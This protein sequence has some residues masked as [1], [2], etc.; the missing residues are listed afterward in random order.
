MGLNCRVV[1]D[2]FDNVVGVLAPNGKESVL[3]KKALVYLTN[4]ETG[5]TQD[6]MNNALTM[7]GS[8]YTQGFEDFFTDE[9]MYKNYQTDIN[10]EPVLTDVLTYLKSTETH[11]MGIEGKLDFES[12]RNQFPEMNYNALESKLYD[13]FLDED[14]NFVIDENKISN[15]GLYLQEEIDNILQDEKV[16]NSIK[17]NVL[18]INK[19]N[20]KDNSEESF[21][22][23]VVGEKYNSFGKL[24]PYDSNTLM[25]TIL[26]KTTDATDEAEFDALLKEV[27]P[28]SLYESIAG[29]KDMYNSLLELSL[30]LKNVTVKRFENGEMVDVL[31]RD[32]NN[33][34]K[35]TLI[36]ANVSPDTIANL[37]TLVALDLDVILNNFEDFFHLIRS[38]EKDL[39]DSN[40][41]V[42]GLS[43]K[44]LSED[45]EKT[46]AFLRAL[47]KFVNSVNR[48]YVSDN[49]IDAYS[50]IYTDYFEIKGRKQFVNVDAFDHEVVKVENEMTK[51]EA[52]ANGL[53]HVRDNFYIPIVS[54]SYNEILE[55]MMDSYELGEN[56]ME[57]V[58]PNNLASE[59]QFKRY[60][61]NIV[62]AKINDF[63]E[64]V[65]EEDMDAFRSITL[66][67]TLYKIDNVKPKTKFTE[68]DKKGVSDYVKFE[69]FS[70][71]NNII[72]RAKYSGSSM[73]EK[74]F[75]YLEFKQD[76]LRITDNEAVVLARI[77]NVLPDSQVLRE[78]KNYF[79]EATV[80]RT[81]DTNY[82]REFYFTNPNELSF[83][84]KGYTLRNEQ[85]ITPLNLDD[86]IQTKEGVFEK[87]D[88]VNG[89]NVY[90][91]LVQGAEKVALASINKQFEG[92]PKVGDM[93]KLNNTYTEKQGTRIMEEI[94]NCK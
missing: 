33:E 2:N 21:L 80:V 35:E 43:E 52:F 15:S 86:F 47:D 20:F 94:N 68:L 48:G 10:G 22:N 76:E 49:I 84:N 55:S 30:S 28:E 92:F 29:N 61:D 73:Y 11:R 34:L 70:D 83:I 77:E 8:A 4:K 26:G 67:E 75:K 41:D 72:I 87:I 23:L 88:N 39:V 38:V 16:Q 53:L 54:S 37:Q 12:F 1:K 57:G 3:F 6:E 85:L 5:H 25:N 62:N 78:L 51:K 60:V 69:F 24:V 7:F 65:S 63:G 82:L 79:K 64:E 66:L 93:V 19:E 91:M 74:I 45:I 50:E 36:L 59:T 56:L 44:M 40:I 9:N 27:L 32:I 46:H 90:S 13:A 42:V 58:I 71:L 18:A 17:E 14:G 89:A 81:P 31:D